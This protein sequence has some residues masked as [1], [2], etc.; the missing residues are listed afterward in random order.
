MG[1]PSS[2]RWLYRVTPKEEAERL[3]LQAIA[4]IRTGNIDTAKQLVAASDKLD[5]P[6]KKADHATG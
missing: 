6:V 2:A 4:A 1:G 5:P 3:R